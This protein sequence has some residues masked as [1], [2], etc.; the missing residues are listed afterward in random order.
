[1]MS[2]PVRI[3]LYLQV[4]ATIFGPGSFRH[5]T[6]TAMIIVNQH[7]SHCVQKTAAG[8]VMKEPMTRLTSF[9]GGLVRSRFPL[10]T[11][12]QINS[13]MDRACGTLST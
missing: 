12:D 8:I 7:C 10:L 2:V 6:L 13:E 1:M 11:V 5:V 9:W 4:E 3:I